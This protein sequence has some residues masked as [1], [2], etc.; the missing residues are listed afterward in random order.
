MDSLFSKKINFGELYFSLKC[1]SDALIYLN[2]TPENQDS[3]NSAYEIKIG[4]NNNSQTTI[5]KDDSTY[6]TVDTSNI[7]DNQEKKLFWI[8]WGA[9]FLSVGKNLDKDSFIKCSFQNIKH[10]YWLNFQSYYDAEWVIY[11]PPTYKKELI[12]LHSGPCKNNKLQSVEMNFGMICLNV[13]GP[14]FRTKLC[15]SLI[16]DKMKELYEVEINTFESCLIKNYKTSDSKNITKTYFSPIHKENIRNISKSQQPICFWLSWFDRCLTMGIENDNEPIIS[17]KLLSL[18][19][20]I[21][22][23]CIMSK[24]SSMGFFKVYS[25]K[26]HGI[27]SPTEHVTSIPEIE[28]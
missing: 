9:G 10:V 12:V 22:C 24:W 4:S 2:I 17:S 3:L 20:H 1:K 21:D 19:F 16:D 18:D 6:I 5:K 25:T 11:K 28:N 15:S 23:I 7:L 14:K 8:K 27:N 26:W 13:F